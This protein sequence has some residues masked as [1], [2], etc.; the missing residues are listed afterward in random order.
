MLSNRQLFLNY[1]AQTSPE[2]LMLEVSYA[3][4][5]Y[6]YSST[7][8]KYLDLI[9]GVSVSALGHSHPGVI[10]ELKVQIDKHMHVMVYGEFIQA[11]QVNY[12]KVLCDILGEG[13]ESVYFVNSGAEAVEGCIKLA[14][15]YTGRSE[16]ISFENAYHG[17]T[18]GALSIMGGEMYKNGYYPLIPDTR[19]LRFN[20]FDDI[21]WITEKTSCV[22]M[23]VIQSEAGVFLPNPGFLERVRERCLQTGTLLA[24]DEIQT[25]F[26]RTGEMFA[27]QKYKVSPDIILLAKSLGGGMPLGAFVSSREIMKS[28]SMN[29]ALGHITTFG[30]HPVSCAAGLACL[31]IILKES[32]QKT[33]LIKEKL[34]RENLKHKLVKEIRGTG[35]L[36]AIDIGSSVSMHQL[37]KSAFNN[38]LITDWFL[39]NDKSIRVSP[40]LN[41]SESEILEAC[42]ILTNSMDEQQ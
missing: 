6:L 31:N 11:P 40:P 10:E 22:I 12:A 21:Q 15:K 37:V 30:G 29:P 19:R 42:R 34:F 7:G 23:E 26:G 20:N 14:R 38:G 28:L 24:F 25:G 41:I 1:L 17:S 9:A 35:L 32:L 8:K 39:F 18:L 13:F 4:G 5:I 16:I 2:P 36:L 33:V 27:F 3:K